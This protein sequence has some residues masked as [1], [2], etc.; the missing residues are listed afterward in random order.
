MDTGQHPTADQRI[1]LLVADDHTI[2]RRGL[3]TLLSLSARFQV[4]GEAED[5]RAAT[6]GT[7]LS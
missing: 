3:I 5:G 1:T 7:T 4:V 2:V 6:P